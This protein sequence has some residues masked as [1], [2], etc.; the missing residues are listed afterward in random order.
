MW[1]LD[2]KCIS[3]ISKQKLIIFLLLLFF[4][5]LNIYSGDYGL[6]SGVMGVGI[7]SENS[8]DNGY[9][10]GNFFN[11]VYQS[12]IGFGFEVSPLSIFWNMK[13]KSVFSSTFL[14]ATVF[15]NFLKHK[16][17]VFGLFTKVH[18][19]EDIKP[20]YFGLQSGLMFSIREFDDDS[21]LFFGIINIINVE[22]GYTY[23]NGTSA[24]YTQVGIDALVVAA[25]FS[26]DRQRDA[27][28]YKK[29]N[30]EEGI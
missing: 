25:L 10:F 12:E 11:F 18:M 28:N 24:F 15:Y 6:S 3:I 23:T 5:T 19:L 13:D 22:L 7:S 29:D 9:L 30:N 16:Y 27:D 4:L 17:F 26:G 8:F 21:I 14:N 2:R 20:N 1:F